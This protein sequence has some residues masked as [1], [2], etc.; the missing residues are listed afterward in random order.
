M[1]KRNRDH[2]YDD[3]WRE[4]REHKRL[5]MLAERQY[6]ECEMIAKDVI[7]A[8]DTINNLPPGRVITKKLLS[9][10]CRHLCRN[11]LKYYDREVEMPVNDLIVKTF[12]LAEGVCIIDNNR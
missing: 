9:R 8:L 3:E 4:D 6:E 12:K 11:M 5:A 10:K 7:S 1:V 2:D